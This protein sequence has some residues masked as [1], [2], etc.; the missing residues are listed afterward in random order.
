[1]RTD[2]SSL[3]WLTHFREPQGQL[4][5]WLEELSQYN[6]V[7]PHRAGRR[8]G[9]ADALSRRP[10]MDGQCEAFMSGVRPEDLPC[11]GC[12]YCVR[13][14]ETWAAFTEEVDEAVPL[15]TTGMPESSFLQ[16][17]GLGIEQ[18][19]GETET[20]KGVVDYVL[21]HDGDNG[22]TVQAVKTGS[23]VSS[24]HSEAEIEPELVDHVQADII[25]RGGDVHVLTVSTDAS[26][27]LAC[28]RSCW[29]FSL[30][31]LREA[32]AKDKDLQFILEWLKSSAFLLEGELFISSPASKAY[33]L[34][35]EQFILIEGVL[36][37]ESD[38]V[39]MKLIVPDGL[40]ETAVQLNHD[41]PS[42][43]HQGIARTKERVKEKFIWHGMG[44]Y[45]AN[46]VIGCEVC[47]RHKKSARQ[48]RCSLTEYQAGAPMERVHLDFLGPL[49]DA[50]GK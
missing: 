6:M 2:H 46:Y 24:S 29:G 30:E 45:V 11:G 38:S 20:V 26:Q 44:K 36:Y 41:L 37:Q 50:Q 48:G 40:K 9:N 1:M 28:K 13:A 32:Q 18:S 7:L 12:K 21:C 43:G 14:H 22:K 25:F 3:V 4:A 5:R 34:N 35:K 17:R 39:D 33:W 15:A 42:A 8:H 19:N 16:G 31:D 49:P 10:G 27:N 23:Q 47:N